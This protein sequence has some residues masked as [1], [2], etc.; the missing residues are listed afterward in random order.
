VSVG[1]RNY[2]IEGVSGAGKT[3]VAEELERRGQHVVHGD[4]ELAYLGDPETGQ[5]LDALA[6][7]D[8]ADRIRW[9]HARHIWDVEKVR[10]LVADHRHAT[11]FFCGGSRNSHH[12]IDLFDG[13]FVLE[14][15]PETLDRRLAGRLDDEFGGKPLERALVFRVHATREDLPK[16]AVSIDATAPVGRIVDEILSRC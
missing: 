12:F 1:I 2:L 10:S 8:E 4:R 3:T 9:R 5:P 16:D 6:G 11:S 15:D 7:G 13:V 14:V